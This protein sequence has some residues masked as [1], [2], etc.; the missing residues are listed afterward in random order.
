VSATLT[1]EASGATVGEAKW[2]ALRELERLAPS[3]DRSAVRFQVLTE[4]EQGLLGVGYVPARVV[5]SVDAAAGTDA[6]AGSRP[7]DETP[8]AAHV[9]DVLEHVIA[10]LGIRC[11]V[12]VEETDERLTATCDGPEVGLLIGRHGS[13]IDAVQVLVAAIAGRGAGEGRKE[14]VVDAAGYRERRRLTLEELALG[15]AEEALR[16]GDPVPLEPMSAPERRIV[17]ERLKAVEGVQ[18]TSE[19]SEPN[20][21]VVVERA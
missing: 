16:H 7:A 9:R 10:A 17:H 21:R 12:E 15:A 8:T 6:V 3:L 4:G 5:A 13:T 20:R 11:R 14:I 1:A 2:K 18:T 19:G